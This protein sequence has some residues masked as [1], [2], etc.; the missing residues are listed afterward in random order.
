MQYVLN[1]IFSSDEQ[2]RP[3]SS[4]SENEFINRMREHMAEEVGGYVCIQMDVNTVLCV[5]I[6]KLKMAML[7]NNVVRF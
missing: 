5:V 1:R 2:T 7:C 3:H 6:D 4:M